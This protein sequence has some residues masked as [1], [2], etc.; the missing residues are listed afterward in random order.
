METEQ[1]TP[2]TETTPETAAPA[3]AAPEAPE[4]TEAQAEIPGVLGKLTP[5]EQQ[6]LMTIKQ[7]SQQ[8]LAKVGE[9]EVLKMRVL[10]KLDELDEQGQG[11]IN[12]ISKRFGLEGGQQWV[13][14]QDG[15]VR[16]VNPPQAGQTQGG[17]PASS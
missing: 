1:N 3:A 8:L 10:A 15:T 12:A 11:H 6:A 2:T 5:E 9:H 14:L 16:V 17:A 13:A 7:Q 4:A